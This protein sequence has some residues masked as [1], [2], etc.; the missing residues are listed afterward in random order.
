MRPKSSRHNVAL[1]FGAVGIAVSVVVAQTAAS[2][3]P[4]SVRSA[5]LSAYDLALTIPVV[6]EVKSGYKREYFKHWVDEDSD[7]CDTREEVLIRDSSSKAQVDAYGCK[8]IAG[9]WSS[10]YDAR[11]LTDPSDIDIDHVVALK[12]AWDSGAHV[13]SAS[14]RQR[15]ANDLTDPRSLMAVTDSVN[16]SKG[17]RDPS[18]WLP[19]NRGYWCDYLGR[20]VAVKA[21]WGLSM[22]QSEAGRVRKL[23][24]NECARTTVAPIVP[25]G[26]LASVSPT[27][28]VPIRA[29]RPT[30]TVA[31][32]VVATTALVVAPVST[33]A[34]SVPVATA[35]PSVVDNG[36]VVSRPGAFCAPGGARGT[37]NGRSYTCTTSPTESRNRWRQP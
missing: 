33:P 5:S 6:A 1:V 21:R 30:T 36:A 28:T 31:R 27:T 14:M 12:E 37:Y 34:T 9:D 22:D 17:D 8:V 35:Q 11:K 32:P 24:Q 16:R 3:G 18:N 4:Q 29:G 15:F 10:P 2:S 13:W 19:P 7:G 25:V 26:G 20:W 23:L